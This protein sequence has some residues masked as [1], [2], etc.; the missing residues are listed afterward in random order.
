[1]GYITP[2]YFKFPG[3]L[4]P[5]LGLKFADVPNGLAALSKPRAQ[6]LEG[7]ACGCQAEPMVLPQSGIRVRATGM[8]DQRM[9]FCEQVVA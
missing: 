5:S 4:S 7:P 6:L 3:F 8:Q 1:M 2:E 9:S